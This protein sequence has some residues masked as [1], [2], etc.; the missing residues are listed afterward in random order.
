MC[1][2]LAAISDQPLN[3]AQLQQGLDLLQHRGPD[4]AALN[5]YASGSIMLGHRRLKVLDLNDR[6]NQPMQ[7]NCG[8]YHI[9]FNGE[10]YNFRDLRKR[11][12]ND[13]ALRTDGD[14]EVLLELYVRFGPACLDLLNGM[15][16]FVVFDS[17]SRSF[18]AARDR[19]GIKPL[20]YTQL[21]TSF[22]LASEPQPLLGFLPTRSANQAVIRHYLVTGDYDFGTDTFFQGIQR[23]DAGCCLSVQQHNLSVQRKQWY[24][25]TDHLKSRRSHVLD[26]EYE[27]EAECIMR[28][29]IR[30]HLVSDV[31]VGLNL[32]G[33]VDSSL[34]GI[35]AANEGQNLKAFSQD[36]PHFSER[37]WVEALSAHCRIP[38]HYTTYT[39]D[40][41]AALLPTVVRYQGEPF[42]GLGV[43]G[44]DALYRQAASEGVTVLLDGNG[45]DEV[46][47]GYRKYHLDWIACAPADEKANRLKDFVNFWGDPPEQVQSELQRNSSPNR[48]I[49]GTLGVR[50]DLMGA[51]L[52][53]DLHP[54]SIENAPDHACPVRKSA[55]RDLV[56][57]KVPRGLRFNDRSSMHFSRELRVPFLDHEWVE[58]AC[59]LPGSMLLGPDGSKML[60]RRVLRRMAG[61]MLASA[62][63]R[64]IQTPQHAWLA[65]PLYP[66]LQ[67]LV[68]STRFRDRGWVDSDGALLALNQFKRTGAPNCFFLW[69]WLNLELWARE[70]IDA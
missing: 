60:V 20:Y 21:D 9:V 36:W 67:D 17:N 46:A 13:I 56:Y 16:A 25:L 51:R 30:R 3:R 38:C 12:L 39:P 47:L 11:F 59:S 69:Q 52:V 10:I 32:S 24:R 33:G 35:L 18:F 28:R 22:I 29:C 2:I 5:S 43:I 42:G 8:R 70:F 57:S 6:A 50:P 40:E 31:P 66:M 23:L 44:Y 48:A 34:L 49:D 65:G 63:K 68:S 58:F 26:P 37:P 41:V 55:L 15:F 45:M 4:A 14:T 19:F 27:E 1:G 61:S 53:D 7:S 64:S 62:P 54:L